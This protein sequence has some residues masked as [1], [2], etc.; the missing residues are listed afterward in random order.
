ML[1]LLAEKDSESRPFHNLRIALDVPS[2]DPLLLKAKAS[3]VAELISQQVSDDVSFKIMP[4]ELLEAYD[5]IRSASQRGA[6]RR[7]APSLLDPVKDL[8]TRLFNSLFQGELGWIYRESAARA[9]KADARLRICIS[10]TPGTLIEDLPWEFLY[11]PTRNDFLAL[12]S[13]RPIVRQV[14]PI[15]PFATSNPSAS[16]PLR[17][18][19]VTTP[20]RDGHLGTE[21]DL[22][23]LQRIAESEAGRIQITQI[24]SATAFDFLEI[25]SSTDFDAVHFSGSANEQIPGAPLSPQALVLSGTDGL[26]VE[27]LRRVKPAARGPRLLF[28][29][30]CNTHRLTR[31]FAR[32]I[33]NVIGMREQV[34]VDF[35]V[36]FASGFYR[37]LMKGFSIEEAISVA[38]ALSDT[39]NPGGRE[40]GM[41]TFSTSA[42]API[43]LVNSAPRA[44]RATGSRQPA[45]LGALDP[46]HAREWRKLKQQLEV[47]QRNQAA[48]SDLL[49]ELNKTES[50]DE[51]VRTINRGPMKD[52]QEQL[53]RL[54]DT[55]DEIQNRMFSISGSR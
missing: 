47:N 35:C 26:T 9:D 11:D 51:S 17:L 44:S 3:C 16:A 1:T 39:V 55:I 23:I 15:V 37:C 30:A 6:T 12:S 21:R 22:D 46:G 48:L 14:E 42:A 36:T 49:E 31:Q 45:S 10:A 33:P 29:N 8:G 52:L 19:F 38:R 28:L 25:M 34:Q 50:P 32:H 5:T 4:H 40:W 2:S 13:R 53:A 54:N 27:M 18:A 7:G 20:D 43:P 24:P 41:A